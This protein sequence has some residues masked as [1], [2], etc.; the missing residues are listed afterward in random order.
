MKDPLPSP[1]A[2]RVFLAFV[3]APAL[4]AFVFACYCPLYSGLPDLADRILE[5]FYVY[6]VVGAYPPSLLFGLPAYLL[7]RNRLRPTPLNCAIVGAIIASLPC[8]LIGL[9]LSPDY[10]TYDGQVTNRD[11]HLTLAGLVH[12][13]TVAGPIALLG[14][15]TGVVF[16]AV[17]AAGMRRPVAAGNDFDQ[18]SI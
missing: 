18:N 12:L 8:V 7:L 17:A 9:L 2:D 10:A 11:G 5:T 6:L 4:A 13:T 14:S 15:F 16:W 1:P 3:V